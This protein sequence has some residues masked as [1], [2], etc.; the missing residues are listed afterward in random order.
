MH[1]AILTFDGFNALDSRMALGILDRIRKPDW[2][3]MRSCPSPTVCYLNGVTLHAQSTL[4]EADD[5]D[6]VLAVE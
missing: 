4:A 1:I 2:R 5:V 3:V 6:A